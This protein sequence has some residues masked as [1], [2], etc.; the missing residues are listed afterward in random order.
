M[1]F[2]GVV[3]TSFTLPSKRKVSTS[4]WISLS[5][6]PFPASSLAARRM[7]KKSRYLFLGASGFSACQWKGLITWTLYTLNYFQK[8]M[9][10]KGKAE[11]KCL[12][13]NRCL[14]QPDE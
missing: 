10:Q 13:H 3:L 5:D 11:Y 6:N 12:S 14:C 7:S 9:S 1:D 4:S 8:S 2:S